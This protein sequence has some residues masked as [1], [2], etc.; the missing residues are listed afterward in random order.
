MIRDINAQVLVIG[1]GPAGYSSAF[2]SADLGLQ[3]VLVEKYSSLGGVCLNVGCIPS[4]LLLHFAKVIKEAKEISKQGVIFGKP[5]IDFSLIKSHKENIIFN[6][7]SGLQNM[8]QKRNIDLL[9]GVGHFVDEKT[10][11]VS[12]DTEHVNIHFKNIILATGSKP[13]TLPNMPNSP[14]I[15]NS[16]QALSLN[17]IP[18]RL[19]IVG[20]GII[21]LEMATFYSSIGVKVDV[22]DRCS[23]LLPVLDMDVINIFHRSIKQDFNVL[24]ETEICDIV[25]HNNGVLV[26]LSN[27]D[28]REK[29]FYNSILI[30]IGR[31]SNIHDLGID[32]VGI[33]V[34]QNNFIIVDNQ[35]RTN[36]SSIYAIGD[37]IG[38]PMLAH[39]G[40]H[41]GHIVAEV[42]AGYKHYFDP[43]VIPSVAYTDPEIAWVG[44]NEMEAIKQ[45][46][47]YEVSIFPWKASG[48]AIVSNCS[49]GMTKL[50]VNK[51]NNKII[52]GVIIGRQAG[53]LISEITLAIEMECDMEDISLTIHAHPTLYETIGL[54]SQ[55]FQGSITDLINLKCLRMKQD[56]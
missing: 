54:S 10:F 22:I 9:Q 1:S 51:K 23:R 25:L 47:D 6:L 35:L 7:S 33:K 43:R 29:V 44:I 26:T 13:V 45:G 11:L 36:V 4:K 28:K 8:M 42:I 40:M 20:S 5:K 55:I 15:W 39:K 49:N 37:V 38:E 21:G 19:L 16:T 50:I 31:T 24:L 48:R 46:I 3:T 2:R 56:I 18:D 32:T 14:N 52:G 53:E 41:Q 34:D 12:N 27:N 30:A 17:S